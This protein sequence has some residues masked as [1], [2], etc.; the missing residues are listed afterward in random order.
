MTPAKKS[1]KTSA[2]APLKKATKPA[3][4][5]VDTGSVDWQ[6]E[7]QPLIQ[8]YKG[9]RHPL[10]YNDTYELVVMVVLSAQDSDRNINKI[11]PELFGAFPDMK[12]LST[13]N[14]ESI[15]PFVS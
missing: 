10:D 2:K 7:I 1:A 3:K 11:A 4:Q 14:V 8:K 15:Y 6:T 13:A 9:K 5:T 12:A